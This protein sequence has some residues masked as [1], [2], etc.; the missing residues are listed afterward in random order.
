ME[1]S[2]IGL[3]S[4]VAV[5]WGVTN[6]LLRLTS[7]GMKRE[8][9]TLSRQIG[10][11]FLYLLT[12]VS[13]WAV[14]GLNQAGSLLFYWTLGRVPLSTAVPLANSGTLVVSLLTEECIGT[15]INRLYS[16]LGVIFVSIG[17]YLCML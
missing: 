1:V 9:A 3:L 17:I 4:L 13:Y 11:D 16:Y 15:R 8:S 2:S 14:F 10:S 12:N 7:S 5:L 6:P